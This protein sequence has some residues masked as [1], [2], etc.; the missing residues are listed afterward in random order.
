[1]SFTERIKSELTC[2]RRIGSD[3]N[4]I[5]V[6]SNMGVYEAVL[7]IVLAG[8]SGIS[9]SETVDAVQ[10][11]FTSRP[12]ILN[13]LKILRE[14]ELINSVPGP[15]KSQVNLVASEELLASLERAFDIKSDI[16]K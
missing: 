2:V 12:G 7:H 9:V 3:P 13:R 16:E 10:S 1:M 5:A 6:A 4:L 14:A 15:K 11:K 8:P